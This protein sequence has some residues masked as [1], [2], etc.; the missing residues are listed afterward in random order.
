[1]TFV[2]FPNLCATSDNSQYRIE[3]VGTPGKESFRDQSHFAYRLFHLN[4]CVWEWL[5]AQERSETHSLSDFPYE[6]WV[7]DDGWVVV[8]THEWFHAGLLVFSPNGQVVLERFH[9]T[10][11]DK[12]EPGFLDGEPEAY[13]AGWLQCKEFIPELRRLKALKEIGGSGYGQVPWAVLRTLQ[14]YGRAADNCVAGRGF[15][16]SRIRCTS[17]RTRIAG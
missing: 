9:R 8:R 5:P 14:C 11:D 12:N 1:M 15:N 6:A 3:I 10:F 17:Q 13:H 4:H 2:S 7:N 16:P